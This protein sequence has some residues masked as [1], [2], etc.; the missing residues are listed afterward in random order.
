MYKKKCAK[1]L[2]ISEEEAQIV[3]DT[4]KSMIPKTFAMVENNAKLAVY[5]GGIILNTRTNTRI[6]YPEAL[7]ARSNN[8]ELDFMVKV[9]IEGSARNAPIQGTQADMI[10]ESIV[11][12]NKYIRDCN[13]DAQLLISVHDELVYKFDR[14]ITE[15][16]EFVKRILL[17]TCNKYLSFITMGAEYHVKKSW[18]K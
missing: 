3:L 10:K 4:I 18:T 7:K 13:I 2:N 14:D 11:V 6:W 1:T 5:N 12:I 15:F 16:P 9:K 17:Q 8:E